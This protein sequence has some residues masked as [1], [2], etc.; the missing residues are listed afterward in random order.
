MTNKEIPASV[1]PEVEVFLTVQQYLSRVR[2]ISGAVGNCL[3]LPRWARVLATKPDN[4][5]L[6]PR[7]HMVEKENHLLQV[8]LCSIHT[9]AHL[10][11]QTHTHT[12]THIHAIFF[13]RETVVL[14]DFK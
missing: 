7:T 10:H 1:H 12:C 5:N 4:L 11:I 2:L 3:G 9:R 8:A 13:K 14:A 6:N